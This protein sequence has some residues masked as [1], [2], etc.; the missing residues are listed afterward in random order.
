MWTTNDIIYIG[1]DRINHMDKHG[2]KEILLRA[3]KQETDYR[4]NYAYIYQKLFSYSCLKGQ[5]NIII[6]LVQIYFD[7]LSLCD[8]LALRQN[9]FYGKYILPKT[10]KN[11]L[12]WYNNYIIP[13]FT[14]K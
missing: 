5:Q 14:L 12:C 4:F 2:L 3:N 10:N 7:F 1:K 8:Q 13:I 9:V 11:L 6:F